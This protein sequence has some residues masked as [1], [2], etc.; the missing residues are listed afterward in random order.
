M[1][2]SVMVRG[3][4]LMALVELKKHVPSGTII[5]NRREKRNAL[6]QEMLAGLRQ[7]L[8]D[9][10]QERQVRAVILTGAGEAFC[11]GMDLE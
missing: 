2:T 6:S 10:R 3:N 5:L 9:F 8:E 7:A 4:S 11:S 1:T